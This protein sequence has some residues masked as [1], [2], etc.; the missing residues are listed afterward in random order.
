MAVCSDMLELILGP[1]NLV[2]PPK[3]SPSAGEGTADP[4]EDCTVQSDVSIA[5]TAM[6]C[7]IEG[8]KVS[9]E[10]PAGDLISTGSSPIIREGTDNGNITDYKG[11]YTIR[12]EY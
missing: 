11:P 2:N 4:R 9:S 3:D 7:S 10:E 6:S 8:T 12:N 1:I 5:C